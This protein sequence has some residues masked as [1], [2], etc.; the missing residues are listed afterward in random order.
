MNYLQSLSWILEAVFAFLGDI[1]QWLCSCLSAGPI[2]S[3]LCISCVPVASSF[4]L[5]ILFPQ[6]SSWYDFFFKYRHSF[7]S[8]DMME[9]NSLKFNISLAFIT[10]YQF[11]VWHFLHSL[12]WLFL[13]LSTSVLVCILLS[14]GVLFLLLYSMYLQWGKE[15]PNKR[16]LR[17]KIKMYKKH[18]LF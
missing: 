5:P 8:Y 2:L 1:R 15:D 9:N 18:T 7:S 14:L 3:A 11:W 16:Q 4:F 12:F 6:L 13:L 17:R 10:K